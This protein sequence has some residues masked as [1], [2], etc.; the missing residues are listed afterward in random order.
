ME[1][2]VLRIL[3]S[4]HNEIDQ[5]LDGVISS[6]NS[7]D[8]SV[9]YRKL[10]LFWARLAIHIRAEHLHLFPTLLDAIHENADAHS[11]CST[12][13][14]LR[15]DHNFFMRELAHVIKTRQCTT[16]TVDSIAAR[17]KTHN[18]IEETRI[19]PLVDTLL[20]PDAQRELAIKMKRELDNLPPRFRTP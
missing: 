13:E 2:S 19:Y 14:S 6:L 18:E 9:W 1:N 8:S 4:D 20:S 17:L 10:D 16:D 3:G 11:V 15:E 7:N 12:V 5:L